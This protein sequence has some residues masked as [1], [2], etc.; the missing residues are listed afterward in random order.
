MEA[1]ALGRA[2]VKALSQSEGFLIRHVRPHLTRGQDHAQGTASGSGW[3]EPL[4]AGETRLNLPAPPRERSSDWSR[5]GD[6]FPQLGSTLKG[7]QNQNWSN[8]SLAVMAQKSWN[9]G[10]V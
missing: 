9:Y 3:D 4:P 5:H 6:D 1:P 7:E 8:Q 10:M 2:A